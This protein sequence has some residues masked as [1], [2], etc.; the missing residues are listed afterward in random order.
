MDRTKFYIYFEGSPRAYLRLVGEHS[1]FTPNIDDATEFPDRVTAEKLLE[2]ESWNMG[3]EGKIEQ[4]TVAEQPFLVAFLPK[5]PA[6]GWK[7][8]YLDKRATPKRIDTTY[9][10]ESAK[11]FDGWRD[12]MEVLSK[13]KPPRGMIGVV[14]RDEP[15]HMKHYQVT[16]ESEMGEVFNSTFKVSVPDYAALALE[17]LADVANATRLQG[18]PQFKV[19]LRNTTNNLEEPPQPAPVVETDDDDEPGDE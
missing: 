3:D 14:F 12:A 2:N 1:T 15:L 16:L 10:V 11:R 13:I 9:T 4:S 5:N 8:K 6:S 7:T 17:I 19:L 18:Q